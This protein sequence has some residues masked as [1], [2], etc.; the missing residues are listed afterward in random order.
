MSEDQPN[1][2]RARRIMLVMCG[3]A[4]IFGLIATMTS[5][6]NGWHGTTM[7]NLTGFTNLWYNSCNVVTTEPAFTLTAYISKPWYVQQQ[8]ETKYLPVENNICVEAH[9]SLKQPHAFWGQTIQVRNYARTPQGVQKDT[10]KLLC[11]SSRDPDPAKLEVGPCF[12][13]RIPGVTTGPYWVLAYNEEAGYALVSGGQ[14]WKKNSNGCRTGTGI[15]HSGL[16]I[17]TRQRARNEQLVQQVRAIAQQKG[18]DL[19][20]LNDVDQTANCDVPVP[21][22]PSFSNA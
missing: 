8:M 4:A 20:V 1:P 16:W 3:L 7:S 22:D 17:L 10:E 2:G 15:N 14:P 21:V 9:Y 18:F 19:T 13:P 11:A 12:L 5:V 6:A